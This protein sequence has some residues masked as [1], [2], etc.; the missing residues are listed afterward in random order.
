MAYSVLQ[1]TLIPVGEGRTRSQPGPDTREP[2][3]AH[4]CS[5]SEL[6]PR[7]PLLGVCQR[8][9]STPTNVPE[10]C[11]NK[12]FFAE[13]DMST[14]LV[15]FFI[16]LY[17][18]FAWCWVQPKTSPFSWLIYPFR[19][20]LRWLGLAHSWNMF[21]PTPTRS[22]R[23][24]QAE[25]TFASGT[26][27]VWKAPRLSEFNRFDAFLSERHKKFQLSVL[28]S[29]SGFV[30][31]ALCEYLIRAY[32]SPTDPP[33]EVKLHFCI[34]CLQDTNQKNSKL[35]RKYGE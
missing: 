24:M 9:S 25:L 31:P 28:K 27:R 21:A 13:I 12:F 30:R 23:Y 5:T 15:N 10:A 6:D 17:L 1:P 3:S 14:V 11:R 19:K 4:L 33:V 29:T 18:S 22:N 20:Y 2:L 35:E 34:S 16:V 7:S 26:V 32:D 8:H